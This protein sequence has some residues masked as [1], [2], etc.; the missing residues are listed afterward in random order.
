MVVDIRMMQKNFRRYAADVQAG[1]SEKWILLDYGYLQAVSYTH[2]DVYKR[3]PKNLRS[4][5]FL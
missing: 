1:A 3:Q 5:R 2:L 4:A